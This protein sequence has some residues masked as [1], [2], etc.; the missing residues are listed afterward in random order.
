[1]KTVTKICILISVLASI[2]ATQSPIS[3]TP[4]GYVYIGCYLDYQNALGTIISP[5]L[6]FEKTW[7]SN[8]ISN[9]TIENCASI[10]AN[11]TYTYTGLRNGSE[12][13]QVVLSMKRYIID[14]NTTVLL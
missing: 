14:Q 9:Y 11:A 3:N 1:M 8:S 13:S 6:G 7:T 2:V 12:V 10:C 5:A 4:A